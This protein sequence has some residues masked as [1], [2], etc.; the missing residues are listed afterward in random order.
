[1][2]FIAENCSMA[3]KANCKNAEMNYWFYFFMLDHWPRGPVANV[4]RTSTGPRTRGLKNWNYQTVD[5]NSDS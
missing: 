2:S 3:K 1:M 5:P 4:L